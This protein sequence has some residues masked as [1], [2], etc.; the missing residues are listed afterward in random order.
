L[1]RGPALAAALIA[2]LVVSGCAIGDPKP[3][4]DIT[5]TGALLKA[6]AYSSAVGDT[7]YFWRY[8]TTTAYGSETPHRTVA[9][10]DDDPPSGRR[11]ALLAQPE[12]DVPLPGVR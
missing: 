7:E 2:A 5:D 12:H 3:T 6:D 8:G 4:A 10:A 1:R 11:A 9:I